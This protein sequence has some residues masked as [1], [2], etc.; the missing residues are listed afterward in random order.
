MEPQRLTLL[1][2]PQAKQEALVF[3]RTRMTAQ[4]SQKLIEM[5]TEDGTR[6]LTQLRLDDLETEVCQMVDEITCRAMR[7]VREDRSLSSRCPTCTKSQPAL[8]LGKRD[9]ATQERRAVLEGA[10]RQPG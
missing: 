2:R 9:R 7:G 4:M 6:D 5:L 8:P 1:W 3:Q 10:A